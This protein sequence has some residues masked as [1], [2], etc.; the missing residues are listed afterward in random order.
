MLIKD[1]H[2]GT[3]CA[4]LAVSKSTGSCLHLC[5]TIEVV[6]KPVAAPTNKLWSIIPNALLRATFLHTFYGWHYIPGIGSKNVFLG[7]SGQSLLS[8]GCVVSNQYRCTILIWDAQFRQD[9]QPVT[10]GWCMLHISTG[11]FRCE[12]RRAT[13]RSIICCVPLELLLRH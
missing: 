3:Q 7:P 8:E 11:G 13:K 6:P 4:A 5:Y 12:A 9:N 1:L 2:R 10:T